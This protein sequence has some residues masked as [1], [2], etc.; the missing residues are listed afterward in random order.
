LIAGLAAAVALALLANVAFAA[1]SYTVAAGATVTINE[2]GI[3]RKVTNPAG[4]AG[5]RWI[6]TKTA[7]EWQ[8]F[9]DHPNGLTMAACPTGGTWQPTNPASSCGAPPGTNPSQLG[10]VSPSPQ[11]TACPTIGAYGYTYNPGQNP[12]YSIIGPGSPMFYGF[13]CE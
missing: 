6:S 8:S 2:Q 5:A 9:I 13:H 12:C 3:C 4:A 7:A 10:P 11:G 1:D